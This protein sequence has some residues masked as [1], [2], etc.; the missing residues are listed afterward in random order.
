MEKVTT[1]IASHVF[2]Q[3]GKKEFGIEN[4][5]VSNSAWDTNMIAASAVCLS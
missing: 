2:G 3:T 5:K 4:A 1:I